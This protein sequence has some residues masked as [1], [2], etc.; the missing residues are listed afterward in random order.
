MGMGRR[1]QASCRRT[2]FTR[3]GAAEQCVPTSNVRP[4]RPPRACSNAAVPDSACMHLHSCI[5]RRS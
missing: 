2:L 1:V 3:E 5:N 4:R